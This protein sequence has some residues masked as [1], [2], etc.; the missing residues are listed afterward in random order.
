MIIYFSHIHQLNSSNYFCVLFF[1]DT[2]KRTNGVQEVLT[3][4]S[5][6]VKCTVA[7]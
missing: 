3:I 7:K 2:S 6:T 1:R 4:K 5:D